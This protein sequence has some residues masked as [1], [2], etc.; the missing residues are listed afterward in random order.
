MSHTV[1]ISI[2][3]YKRHQHLRRAL[4]S[5]LPYADQVAEIIVVDNAAEPE[6][7]SLLAAE[8]PN[9]RYIAA[10]SN[11]GCE[12]RNIG[13]RA[14]G[15]PIVITIDDDVEF[16][17]P[18][19]IAEVEAAFSRDPQLACLNFTVTGVDGK[20]LER[21]WCHPRP[22]SHAAREFET[23]FILEGAS[24]LSR[25]KVLSV[26]GYPAEFFLGH[27]GVDLSYRLIGAGYRVVHTPL[28]STT[29]YAASEHR[30]DWRVYY[31]YTRNGIWVAYRSFPP[32]MAI[33]RVLAYLATMGFFSLRANQIPAYLRGCVDGMR[34]L[35]RM[36]RHNLDA[37]SLKHVR[38]IRSERVRLFGRIQRRFRERI[39]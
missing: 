23:H 2:L 5:A 1:T 26:G 31:Y 3:T 4:A 9:V 28:V 32:V 8:Y 18:N 16:S 14:A 35:S 11:A 7:K 34:G 30:P 33:S 38:E 17:S 29:H 15:T 20:V 24:A 12:G 19:C 10:P 13:L 39:L 36:D 22:I 25:E 37:D 21:D 6:L 27:E